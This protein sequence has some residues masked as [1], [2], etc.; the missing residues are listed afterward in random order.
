M[1][2][3]LL[4]ALELRIEQQKSVSQSVCSRISVSLPPLN[5]KILEDPGG[6]GGALRSSLRPCNRAWLVPG[7]YV[8]VR[9]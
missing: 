7:Q 6:G 1:L 8:A 2:S 5:Q 4:I 9:S 3:H